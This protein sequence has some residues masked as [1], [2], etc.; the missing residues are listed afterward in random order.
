[1]KEKKLVLIVTLTDKEG[2]KY[3]LY[4]DYTYQWSEWEA[5]EFTQWKLTNNNNDVLIKHPHQRWELL[6]RNELC[7]NEFIEYAKEAHFKIEF[8]KQLEELLRVK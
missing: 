3:Y 5:D 4:D 8:D 2:E 7:N 6:E 1:M